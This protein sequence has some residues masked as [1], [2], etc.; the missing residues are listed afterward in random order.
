LYCKVPLLIEPEADLAVYPINP[1][2]LPSYFSDPARASA[3]VSAI[4][5][6]QLNAAQHILIKTLLKEGFE[7]KP[8]ALGLFRHS[9]GR[10]KLLCGG[11]AC[12]LLVS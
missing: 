12:C 7:T 11:A 5:A 4:M 8:I 1:P 10:I 3:F 2:I 6:P 9:A